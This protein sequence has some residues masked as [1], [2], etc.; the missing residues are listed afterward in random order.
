M[1]ATLDISVVVI[2]FRF[3]SG[4]KKLSCLYRVH[5]VAPSDTDYTERSITPNKYQRVTLGDNG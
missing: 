1:S 4:I 2:S 3:P 5:S